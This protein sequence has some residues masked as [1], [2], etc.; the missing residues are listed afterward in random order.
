MTG[1]R[2]RGLDFPDTLGTID[3]LGSLTSI[4]PA[5]ESGA[6]SAVE[7][8]SR[9]LTSAEALASSV[10]SSAL[11]AVE[12]TIAQQ[13]PKNVTIGTRLICVGFDTMSDCEEIPVSHS[14]NFSRLWSHLQ[15][16]SLPD[17]LQ[18][19]PSLRAVLAIGLC[20]II[21][22]LSLGMFVILR[23]WWALYLALILEFVGLALFVAVVVY[24]KVLFNAASVLSRYVG[25]SVEQGDIFPYSVATATFCSVAFLLGLAV[26]QRMRMVI[27]KEATT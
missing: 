26:W 11:G 4:V 13:I 17:T 15:L 16:D 9:A 5:L 19:A 3:G 20:C 14:S 7:Q 25:V 24:S 8:A 1:L 10:I 6:A 22:S 2:A 12:S 18:R 27:R 23:H 21:L